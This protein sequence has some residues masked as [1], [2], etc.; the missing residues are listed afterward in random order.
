[1]LPWSTE[2][3]SAER[4]AIG[5]SAKYTLANNA[6]RYPDVLKA[7]REMG[8]VQDKAVKPVL[9]EVIHAAETVQTAAIR[10][11]QLAALEKLKTKGAGYQRDMKLWGHAAQGAIGIGCIVA[12]TLSFTTA[13]LPCVIGGA[14]ASAGINYW[15]ATQ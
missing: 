13:G 5:S 6:A 4:L 14:V 7:L 12:A 2:R 8:P 11:Q 1:M 9:A 3:D 10:K 15:A